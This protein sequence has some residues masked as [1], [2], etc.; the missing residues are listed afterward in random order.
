M[1]KSGVTGVKDGLQVS[2]VFVKLSPKSSNL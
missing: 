1:V 2:F